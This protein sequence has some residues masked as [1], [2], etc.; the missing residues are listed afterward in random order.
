MGGVATTPPRAPAEPAGSA[1][2]R[3]SSVGRTQ[4]CAQMTARTAA[5]RDAESRV[6]DVASWSMSEASTRREAVKPLPGP[7]RGYGLIGNEAKNRHHS[8]DRANEYGIGR[9]SISF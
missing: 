9:S 2:N 1:W 7:V 6:T 5:I 3:P 8:H 4:L